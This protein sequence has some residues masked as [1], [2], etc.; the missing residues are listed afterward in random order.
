M[1]CGSLFVCGGGVTIS[2]PLPFG[3][4]GIEV[5]APDG[6]WGLFRRVKEQRAN[7]FVRPYVSQNRRGRQRFEPLRPPERPNCDHQDQ[8]PE[9]E[10]GKVGRG[11]ARIAAG[12]RA[13]RGAGRVSDPG[14]VVYRPVFLLLYQVRPDHRK[15]VPD[16]GIRELGEDL[17][18]AA[19]GERR[20]ED[21]C[22]GDCT[23]PAARGVRGAGGA[24]EARE[25]PYRKGRNRDYAGT[26][27][28]P[29]P[30]AGTDQF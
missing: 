15:A 26:G 10:R 27:V 24:I 14:S 19:G 11:T 28:L 9:R 4:N 25:L 29:Q 23:R 20:R 6:T 3:S 12:S 18:A 22:A 30:R 21:L 13:A 5:S 16:A 7:L 8:N 1:S 2:K 17:C